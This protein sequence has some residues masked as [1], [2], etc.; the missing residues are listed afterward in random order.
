MA[1]NMTLA[2]ANATVTV[3]E[4][5]PPNFGQQVFQLPMNI[6]SG[7]SNFFT[8]FLPGIP[9]ALITTVV[10]IFR[11]PAAAPAALAAAAIA[12]VA[13][14]PDIAWAIAYIMLWIRDFAAWWITWFFPLYAMGTPP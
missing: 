1:M 3:T 7:I 2:A 14:F 9:A 10:F 5:I 6:L 11:M 4:R 8:H 12:T 13:R